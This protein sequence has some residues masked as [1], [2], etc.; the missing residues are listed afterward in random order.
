MSDSMRQKKRNHPAPSEPGLWV[1]EEGHA[2]VVCHGIA[3]PGALY[4]R[5]ITSS[6]EAA[7]HTDNTGTTGRFLVNYPGD[8]PDC[9]W[10]KVDPP[11]FTLPPEKPE[12]VLAKRR[13]LP[14]EWFVRCGPD[15]LWCVEGAC[16]Y[17]DY[18]VDIIGEQVKE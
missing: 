3:N 9:R 4:A 1:S 11:P 6:C 2:A 17:R 15:F 8:L 5:A 18:D 16:Y 14:P 12:L 10:Q 7:S 13:G